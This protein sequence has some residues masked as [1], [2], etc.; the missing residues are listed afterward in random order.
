MLLR[1]P[2]LFFFVILNALLA[3]SGCEKKSP[4]PP[5]VLAQIKIDAENDRHRL[6]TVDLSQMPTSSTESAK[7]SAT[8]DRIT[9]KSVKYGT[10]MPPLSQATASIPAGTIVHWCP[11]AGSRI[12]PDG[13]YHSMHRMYFVWQDQSGPWRFFGGTDSDEELH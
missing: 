13:T 2:A 10:T 9:V 7:Q 1:S 8:A 3:V 4:V 11:V 5:E 6:V 12:S